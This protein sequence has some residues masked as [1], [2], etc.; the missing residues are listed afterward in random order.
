DADAANRTLSESFTLI[1]NNAMA[2]FEPIATA[3]LDAIVPGLEWLA[4]LV[5][6]NA[7]LFGGLAVGIA[8][9]AAA[10]VSINVAA[11]AYRATMSAVAATKAI[12][13]A[14]GNS[15]IVAAAKA[16]AFWARVLAMYIAEVAR[17]AARS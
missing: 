12:W 13:K 17:A 16:G 9:A 2:A 1:K 14:V 5:Q 7:G 10:I 4:D 11:K 3:V 6:R 15:S 8:G